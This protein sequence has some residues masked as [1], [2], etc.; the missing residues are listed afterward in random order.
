MKRIIS[1]FVLLFLCVGICVYSGIATEK[2]TDIL[3]SLLN[4]AEYSINTGNK[5]K[6]LENLVRLEREWNKA[7]KFFSSVSETA[8]IDELDLSLVSIE[9][10][11]LSDMKEEA[12]IVIE[13][14]RTGLDTILRRQKISVDNIL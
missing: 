3:L 11:I 12:V 6:A 7:E 8:L 4:E 13:Q 2:K 10:Y 1:A 9:K 5:E 14:C